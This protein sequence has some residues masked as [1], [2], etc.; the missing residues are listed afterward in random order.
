METQK[1]RERQREERERERE[2]ERDREREREREEK[3]RDLN[4]TLPETITQL[5]H[6]SINVCNKCACKR[7][8]MLVKI[9]RVLAPS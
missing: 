7:E 3:K 6:P 1:D 5:G 8:I 2:R 9:L 4:T